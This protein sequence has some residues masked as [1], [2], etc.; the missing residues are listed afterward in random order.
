[1]VTVTVDAKGRLSIPADIRGAL[2]INPGDVLF[3]ESDLEHAVL[4]L[5]KAVNP[6]DGLAEH[7][8]QEYRAGRTQNLRAYAAE[9]GI[10]LTGTDE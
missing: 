8:V 6:F 4:H 2:G 7:A 9:R 3:L 1:M 5:A 10:D